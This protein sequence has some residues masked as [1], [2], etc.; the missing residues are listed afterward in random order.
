[1]SRKSAPAPI[2][3]PNHPSK[4]QIQ[5]SASTN[6]SGLEETGALFPTTTHEPPNALQP[7]TAHPS[8]AVS[9][10]DDSSSISG[11]TLARA[12]I[13]NYFV[14]SNDNPS[15]NRCKSG[16]NLARQ[17]SATLPGTNENELLISPYWRDRRISSEDAVRSPD[18]GV[19]PHIPPV[20]PI[21]PSPSSASSLSRHM[22]TE[23]PRKPPSRSQSLRIDHLSNLLSKKSGPSSLASVIVG[24]SDSST[25][26]PTQMSVSGGDSRPPPPQ[27][28]SSQST[29][30]RDNSSDHSLSNPSSPPRNTSSNLNATSPDPA[31]VSV[32]HSQL[33]PS[34]NLSSPSAVT[35]GEDSSRL[36]PMPSDAQDEPQRTGASSNTIQTERTV[37]SATSGEDTTK[38][39]TAYRFV[40]PLKSSF[41]VHLHE[42]PDPSTPPLSP[43]SSDSRSHRTH[44][45]S[46]MTFPQTPYSATKPSR[47]GRSLCV[48]GNTTILTL[49]NCR[50]Q[51]VRHG[52]CLCRL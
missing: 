3:I 32:R 1:L 36:R 6:H 5:R 27:P 23:G 30:P 14:L 4:A 29:S 16:S 24:P 33:P 34:L 10:N 50:A 37:G 46:S 22:P 51:R 43:W 9:L 31:P 35:D 2:K 26:A 41:P 47:S 45:S 48:V 42:S 20:P 49:F 38:L 44:T 18:S 11:T 8:S 7:G 19:D 21:P 13:A 12:L 40:S 25:P 39:L 15:R 28:P 17:D 52:T